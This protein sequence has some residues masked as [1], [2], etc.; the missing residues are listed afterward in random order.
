MQVDGARVVRSRDLVLSDVTWVDGIPTTTPER[1]IVDLGLIFPEH[2]VMRILR[3]AISTGLVNRADV[4]RMRLRTSKQGRNG[5]GI[6]GRCLENLAELAEVAESGLEALFLEIC[7]QYDLSPPVLQ[8]PVMANSRNY[9]LD[10]AYPAR[11]IFIEIDG[12]G[13]ADPVQISNDG[14]R[15]NDLVAHGWQP[16]RFGYQALKSDPERCADVVRQVLGSVNPLV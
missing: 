8:L 11:K 9:R 14:G 1:T 6:T 7:E 3:H 5:T 2:E 10:F 4:I 15:Q 12:S 13:H 16:I